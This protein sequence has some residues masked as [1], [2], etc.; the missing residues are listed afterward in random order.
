VLTG[1]FDARHAQLARSMLHRL[2]LIEDALEEL[3]AVIAAIC[4]PW[5]H[6]LELLQTIP[7]VGR[8]SRR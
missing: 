1:H 5:A 8:R 3:D 2:D 7:G 4:R 6:Q